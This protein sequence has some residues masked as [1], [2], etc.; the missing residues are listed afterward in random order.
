MR[1]KINEKVAGVGPFKNSKSDNEF[2]FRDFIE[3]DRFEQI[4]PLP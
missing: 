4:R 1:A 2:G 3:L